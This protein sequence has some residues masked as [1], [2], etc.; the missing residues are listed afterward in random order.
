MTDELELV[1]ELVRR[2]S[3]I[4]LRQ[5]QRP[6]LEAAIA[7]VV[8]GEDARGFLRLANEPLTGARLVQRLLDEV[9][10]KET[11]FLRDLP[12]LETIDWHELVE[13]GG[14]QARIWALSPARGRGPPRAAP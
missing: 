6:S 10:V 12:Q 1:A 3:G 9:T 13:A 4:A 5:S 8:P 7:R 11:S 14:G 2:E